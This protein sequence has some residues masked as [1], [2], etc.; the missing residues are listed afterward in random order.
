MKYNELGSFIKYL[1]YNYDNGNIRKISN[2]VINFHVSY[3][4]PNVFNLLT[5]RLQQYP[6]YTIKD[7]YKKLFEK[8]Y[9]IGNIINSEEEKEYVKKLINTNFNDFFV[10]IAKGKYDELN[11]E[12]PF[13][14]VNL[15]SYHD[16]NVSKD[17]IY[18]NE[19]NIDKRI[20]IY[21][22]EIYN[23]L[24]EKLNE[25][26]HYGSYK[27]LE[28]ELGVVLFE[29][30]RYDVNPV[31]CDYILGIY[32]RMINNSGNLKNK[33]LFIEICKIRELEIMKVVSNLIILFNLYNIFDEYNS[34]L[35][36]ILINKKYNELLEFYKDILYKNKNMKEIDNDIKYLLSRN[37]NYKNE[38]M[39]DTLFNKLIHDLNFNHGL[40]S[41]TESFD[42]NIV[43]ENDELFVNTYTDKNKTNNNHVLKKEVT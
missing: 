3:E 37:E 32:N 35:Y 27:R 8:L 6:I 23:H 41:E 20:N 40:I 7:E 36:K 9:S 1:N 26:G 31:L 38:V 4:N 30:I 28:K 43:L 10:K 5:F 33:K 24:N 19:N 25:A 21:I 17:T 22:N 14:A 18:I 12:F 29:D 16:V 13:Y 34:Y 42:L 15:P 39:E 2:D 11:P